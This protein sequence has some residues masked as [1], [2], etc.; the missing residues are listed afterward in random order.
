VAV[1]A[2]DAPTELPEALV[3]VVDSLELALFILVLV[4]YQ[5]KVILVVILLVT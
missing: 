3:V 5:D 1:Q 4:E 2:A